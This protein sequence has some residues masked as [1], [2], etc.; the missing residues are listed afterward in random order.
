MWPFGLVPLTLH[1]ESVG[2]DNGFWKTMK[3]NIATQL[4]AALVVMLMFASFVKV[5]EL[6]VVGYWWV[7]IISGAVV[8]LMMFII[9]INANNY[10]RKK[11]S[12]SVDG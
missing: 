12:E 5:I 10:H 6:R 1:G 7:P 2:V 8:G 4:F 9:F 11:Y 3:L